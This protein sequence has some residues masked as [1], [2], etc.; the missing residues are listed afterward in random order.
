MSRG[1][2]RQ[3]AFDLAL[4]PAMGRD[5]FLVGPS[6]E[7]AVGLIDRWPDWP[8]RGLVLIGPPGSGK[9]HLAQVWAGVAGAKPYR[10]ADD[11]S[12]LAPGFARLV[13][14][15]PGAL[16]DTALFHLLNL[17]RE[18]QG[19]VL[20]TAR[21]YPADWP[22][23]LPD[24]A[25]RL[26]ALPAIALG[27]PDDALLRGVLVKLFADRQL[28]IDE[29]AIAYLLARVPRSLEAAR[30]L[31]AEIDRQA[32]EEKANVTRPFVA[33]VLDRLAEPGLF[34]TDEE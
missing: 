5:D 6:N 14:D 15:M 27:P 24:L 19:H 11:L 10:P 21:G 23:A 25:S 4:R 28:A 20:I 33:R 22:V 31:A 16:D 1:G 9:S 34:G 30:R 18:T 32:L 2:G 26:K 12:R 13:E 29:P 7:A 3:L 8:A 17:A